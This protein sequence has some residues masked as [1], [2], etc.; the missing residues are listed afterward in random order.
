MNSPITSTKIE[1]MIKN[2]KKKKKKKTEAGDQIGLQENSIKH[3]EK[4]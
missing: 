2:L 4:S 1:V 3:L